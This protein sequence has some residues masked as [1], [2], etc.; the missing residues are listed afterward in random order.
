MNYYGAKELAE[1]FRT[2]RK[3]TLV[4]AEEVS[5][6]NYSFS[7]TPGTR[8]I[9]QTLIHIA[10]CTKMPEAIHKVEHLHDLAGFN[11]FGLLGPLM[12]QEQ[13]PHTKAEIISLLTENGEKYA[14][15]LETVSDEF[16]GEVVTYPAGMNPPTKTRFEMLLGTKEHEMHHRGQLMVMQRLV[17]VTPHLTRAMQERMALVMA[18]QTQQA[19]A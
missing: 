13:K 16:L 4:I 8:T 19:T 7:A 3:N 17:G 15:W 10:L 1:A 18:Q 12:A 14:S 6:E 9:A 11:F 2:V 5:E